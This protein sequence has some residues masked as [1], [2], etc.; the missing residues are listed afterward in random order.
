MALLIIIYTVHPEFHKPFK[1][2]KHCTYDYKPY[3][4]EPNNEKVVSKRKD[5]ITNHIILDTLRLKPCQK[6]QIKED[7]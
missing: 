5:K 3:T 6:Q 2:Q 4:A 1:V 7:Q